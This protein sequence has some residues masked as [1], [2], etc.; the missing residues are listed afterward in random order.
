MRERIYKRIN[1]FRMI[2]MNNI[3]NYEMATPINALKII[4]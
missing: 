1:F 4:L 2:I 3:N